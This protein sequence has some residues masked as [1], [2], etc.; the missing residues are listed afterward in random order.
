MA[1]LRGEGSHLTVAL[2]TM[3][4]PVHEHLVLAGKL[5]KQMRWPT[6]GD[7]PGLDLKRCGNTAVISFASCDNVLR[8]PSAK[9]RGE[10]RACEIRRIGSGTVPTAWLYPPARRETS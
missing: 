10:L 2:L 9:T 3:L 8:L 4:G 6:G 5:R 7:S 1:S